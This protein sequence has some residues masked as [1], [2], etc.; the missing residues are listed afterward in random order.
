MV[1][2]VKALVYRVLFAGL[3]TNK[4][5]NER[6]RTLVL[7]YIESYVENR[8]KKK[9]LPVLCQLTNQSI[10]AMGLAL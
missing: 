8:K 4:Q 6:E 5:T 10:S 7:L 1:S 9:P 3:Q 2:I